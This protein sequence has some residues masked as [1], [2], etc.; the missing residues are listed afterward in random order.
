MKNKS[1]ELPIKDTKVW[2][3]VGIILDKYISAKS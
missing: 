3:Y 1:S 2:W